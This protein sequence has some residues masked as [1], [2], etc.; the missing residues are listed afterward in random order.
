MRVKKACRPRHREPTQ[1]R[2]KRELVSSS[3]RE[4]G[5]GEALTTGGAHKRSEV[6]GI[7]PEARTF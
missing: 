6:G 3:E 4:G 1:E 2:E 7:A 5:K